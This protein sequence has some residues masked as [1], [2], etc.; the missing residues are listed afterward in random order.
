[1]EEGLLEVN[2]T[3]LSTFAEIGIEVEELA[4]PFDAGR[5]WES[6]TTLRSW[7]V[8]G[9]SSALLDNPRTRDLLKPEAI[10]EIER[11][12]TYSAIDVHRAS[13]IRSEWFL[14]AAELFDTYD[15]LV[16]PTT[17]VWPFPV[18]W[19]SPDTI[20]GVEMD[21]YHRWMEIVIPVALLGLPCLNVPSGFGANGLP[22]G[23]Q[24]FGPRGSDAAIL[25]I[26]QAWHD[27]TTQFRRR[28]QILPQ[29]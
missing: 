28:P 3:A 29:P 12:L 7:A 6:W 25:Q 13:V 26:G 20:A 8:A 27:A 24:V 18:D 10:W 19:R 14:K 11:G 4:P 16:L 2:E 5:I 21:T 22:A 1:M 9:G 23:L 17:Q 15:A